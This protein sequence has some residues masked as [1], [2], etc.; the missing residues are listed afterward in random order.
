MFN[1]ITHN[2]IVLVVLGTKC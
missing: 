1:R 2:K